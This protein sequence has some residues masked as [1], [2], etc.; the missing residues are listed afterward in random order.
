M[1]EP[2]FLIVGY[3]FSHGLKAVIWVRPIRIHLVPLQTIRRIQ[4][5][6]L[7]LRFTTLLNPGVLLL[8][9]VLPSKIAIAASFYRIVTVQQ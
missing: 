8:I 3:V 7:V 6:I 4:T 1:F 2:Y 5:S 9:L